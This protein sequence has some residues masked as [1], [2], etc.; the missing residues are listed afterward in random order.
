MF[1]TKEDNK[2]LQIPTI[3][4]RPNKTQ[5]R[6]TFDEDS[7]R[8]LAQSISTSGILQ[9][10]TVRKLSNTE[11][12]LVAG[13]RRLR[14]AVL[15]GLSKVPCVLI[16]CTDKESAVFALLENL[17]RADLNMFEEARG[18]SRLIRKFD[19]T[20]EEVARRLGKKQSTVANKLRLLKLTF[21][22]Q[23]WILGAGLS[24][25]HA[26][27]LLRIEDSA[28][29][30][31]M[32]SKIIAESLSAKETEDEVVKILY[33]E[34]VTAPKT[35]EQKFVIRDVRIFVNT[36]TKAVD[37][38]RLSGINAESQKRETEQYIEYTVKIPKS[39][40]TKTKPK[41]SA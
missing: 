37:T 8:L 4:I 33:S 15:A 7:L 17:Q 25:R 20:Q 29:R 3:Q 38:M 30:R 22:E 5:P 39:E 34:T 18:I 32:L 36:I 13:E 28:V 23:D 31:E 1:L 19:L 14:A 10:L 21:E 2:V 26:R 9:P 16:K 24:E 12:E 11:Y 40:A 27:A 6:K 35:R 41:R